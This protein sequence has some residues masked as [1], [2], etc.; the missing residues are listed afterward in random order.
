MKKNYYELLGVPEDATLK[1]IKA[2]YQDLQ[3]KYDPK[4]N[5]ERKSDAR[6]KKIQEA[7]RVL[8]KK[9]TRDTYDVSLKESREVV[10]IAPVLEKEEVNEEKKKEVHPEPE[11]KAYFLPRVLA[12]LLDV[13]LISMLASIIFSFFP[14]ANNVVKLNEEYETAS[15]QFLQKELTSEQYLA[16]VMDLM[17][18]MAYQNVIYVIL[19]VALA[20]GYFVVFQFKNGGRTLGKQLMKIKV[21]SANGEE[22]TMNH[23]LFRAAILQAILFDIILVIAVLL[24]PKTIYGSFELGIQVLQIIISITTIF[25]VLFRKDGRGI[26]DFIAGTKVVM[27]GSKEKELCVN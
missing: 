4:K 21:V 2:K 10:D 9:E 13:F 7:Y 19:E 22:L 23:Y 6:W 8:S 3:L 26:H 1:E 11:V 15:E 5:P 17:Y 12:Y 14:Q 25:L 18:D 16:Q 24:L 20:V 27:D